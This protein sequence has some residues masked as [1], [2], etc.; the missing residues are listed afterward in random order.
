M[1]KLILLLTVAIFCLIPVYTFAM[2]SPPPPPTC[3]NNC[4][5]SVPEPTSL[6]LIGLGLLGTAVIYKKI[7]K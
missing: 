4:G 3:T 1:K 2:G 6:L 5:T 7:K